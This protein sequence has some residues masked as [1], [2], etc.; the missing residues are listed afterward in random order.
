MEVAA[1]RFGRGPV[2]REPVQAQLLKAAA[3]GTCSTSRRE[4]MAVA[5]SPAPV[6]QHQ[7]AVRVQDAGRGSVSIAETAGCH[8]WWDDRFGSLAHIAPVLCVALL[9]SHSFLTA[10][11]I[12]RSRSRSRSPSIPRPT[13]VGDS[14]GCTIDRLNC[15]LAGCSAVAAVQREHV[16]VRA[17][18]MHGL[19]RARCC[20]SI[21]RTMARRQWTALRRPVCRS[22]SGVSS[23]PIPHRS[24]RLR[25]TQRL[26]PTMLL[27]LLCT[28]P[29]RARRRALSDGVVRVILLQLIPE[30]LRRDLIPQGRCLVEDGQLLLS[31]AAAISMSWRL[32]WHATATGLS[33]VRVGRCCSELRPNRGCQRARCLCTDHGWTTVGLWRALCRVCALDHV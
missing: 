6:I 3:A 14:A 26:L 8:C 32:A 13:V 29:D 33:G 7:R 24:R 4:L 31:P 2:D 30:A 1:E 17:V 21:C 18:T 19:G 9:L 28:R 16:R 23:A 20:G 11:Y 25:A 5:C 22:S 15:R 27:L 10:C 12:S